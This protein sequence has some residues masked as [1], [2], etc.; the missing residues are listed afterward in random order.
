MLLKERKYLPYDEVISLLLSRNTSSQ[1]IDN[2]Y[3]Q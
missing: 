2:L 3:M 1:L